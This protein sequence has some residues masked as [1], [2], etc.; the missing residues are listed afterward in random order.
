M[1]TYTD[2]LIA[3]TQ[4]LDYELSVLAEPPSQ[5]SATRSPNYIMLQIASKT[6]QFRTY[7]AAKSGQWRDAFQANLASHR[8][9]QRRPAIDLIAHLVAAAIQEMSSCSTAWLMQRCDDEA[10]LREAF[11]ELKSLD[12]KVNLDVLDNILELSTFTRLRRFKKDNPG[13]DMTPG[14][15]GLFYFGQLSSSW[16]EEMEKMEKVNNIQTNLPSAKVLS[17]WTP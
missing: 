15:T 17:I 7:S 6:L 4:R 1:R 5:F 12:K 9:T 8:M 14:K 11:E 13:I 10:V 3:Y 2:K 16:L